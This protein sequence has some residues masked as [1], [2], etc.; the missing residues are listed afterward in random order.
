MTELRLE[1]KQFN[2]KARAGILFLVRRGPQIA[3]NISLTSKYASFHAFFL[4]EEVV[5]IPKATSVC[6]GFA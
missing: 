5:G 4:A 1:P 6:K 3:K 2:L